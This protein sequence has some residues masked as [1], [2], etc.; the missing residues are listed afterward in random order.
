MDRPVLAKSLLN[1]VPCAK[2]LRLLK[3]KI[4]VALL[5]LALLPHHV[6]FIASLELRLA[7]VIEDLRNRHHAFRLRAN[8]HDNVRAGE[9][10]HRAL[11][12]V[13]FTLSFFSFSREAFERGSKVISGGGL[14]L[15]LRSLLRGR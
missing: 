12:H 8:I 1:L 13:V 7:R 9:L 4:D 11:Q 5:R 15:F 2:L 3:R 14:G 10:Y 6:D